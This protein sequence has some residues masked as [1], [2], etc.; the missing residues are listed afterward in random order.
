MKTNGVR[1]QRKI[2]DAFTRKTIYFIIWMT[3]LE[4]EGMW[5]HHNY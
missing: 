4:I 1:Y 3:Y 5:A 2:D